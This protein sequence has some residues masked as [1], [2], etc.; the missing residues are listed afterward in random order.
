MKISRVILAVVVLTLTAVSQKI[1]PRLSGIHALF[2]KGNNQAAEGA[3]K[4]LE[5]DETKRKGC[6]TLATNPKDSDATLEIAGDSSSSEG[7]SFGSLGARN[8]IASGTLTTQGGDVLWQQS[9]RFSDAPFQSGG[10]TAGKLLYL[11]LRHTACGK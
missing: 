11:R 6:L 7:G 8:W 1:D 2:I 4:E 10:K 3:R 9:E 5:K